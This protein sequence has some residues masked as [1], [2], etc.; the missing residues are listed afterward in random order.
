MH[1]LGFEDDSGRLRIWLKR[2]TSYSWQVPLDLGSSI[3]LPAL[4]PRNDRVRNLQDHRRSPRPYRKR[5][6]ENQTKASI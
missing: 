2:E 3:R 6:I 1:V 4:K 5:P